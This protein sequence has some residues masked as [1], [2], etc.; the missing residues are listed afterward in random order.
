MAELLL[1]SAADAR[2]R[3]PADQSDAFATDDT[4]AEACLWGAQAALAEFIGCEPSVHVAVQEIAGGP[5]GAYERPYAGVNSYSAVVRV[6]P[7]HRPVSVSRTTGVT[8]TTDGTG[9]G[10]LTFTT[11]PTARQ[12]SYVAG[13]RRASDTDEAALSALIGL[14]GADVLTAAELAAIPTVPEAVNIALAQAAAVIA[15]RATSPALGL[16]MV[17]NDWGT[18]QTTVERAAYA[19]TDADE[20]RAIYAALVSRYRIPRL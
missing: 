16:S 8:V 3:L 15:R 1:L 13:W 4:F 20:I 17:T 6:Y 2:A 5:G 9:G 12:L 10:F 7:D 19:P 11:T 14:T 18:S